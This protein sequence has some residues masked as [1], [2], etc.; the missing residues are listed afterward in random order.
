MILYY[1]DGLTAGW[2]I[3]EGK[4]VSSPVQCGDM[5]V[6]RWVVETAA[7]VKFIAALQPAVEAP[8]CTVISV[9]Y[10]ELQSHFRPLHTYTH[11][12]PPR[13]N[14]NVPTFTESKCTFLETFHALFTTVYSWNVQD[15]HSHIRIVNERNVAF[16]RVPR[17]LFR[18]R[19]RLRVRFHGANV[20]KSNSNLIERSFTLDK[21]RNAFF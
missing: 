7:D 1:N 10:T 4:L 15:L 18:S 13:Y 8:A 9:R 5:L 21:N 3:F 2:G 17:L 16:W 6:S 14:H 12:I 20:E 11:Q 19:L